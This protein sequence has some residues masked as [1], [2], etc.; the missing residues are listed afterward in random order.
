MTLPDK[1]F[2][3]LQGSPFRIV[4]CA[5]IYS[6][7]RIAEYSTGNPEPARGTST[8]VEAECPAHGVLRYGIDVTT[9]CLDGED[10]SYQ[11]PPTPLSL[12]YSHHR[13]SAY[14][15]VNCFL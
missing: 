6:Y 14:H 10:S 9:F 7:R 13:Q 5:W 3:I 4:L 8:T 11:H 12:A 1:L 15:R 2:L